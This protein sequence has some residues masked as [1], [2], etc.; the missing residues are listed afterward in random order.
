MCTVCVP[1]AYRGQKRV[2][3]PLEIDL[4]M[5]VSYFVSA[6]N[7]TQVL[8]KGAAASALYYWANSLA[9]ATGCFN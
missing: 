9:P 8:C 4:Q 5:T 3:D 1:D 6:R 7:Q 2:V